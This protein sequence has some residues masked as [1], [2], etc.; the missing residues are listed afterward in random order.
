LRH[1]KQ[2]LGEFLDEDL[3]RAKQLLGRLAQAV[4]RCIARLNSLHEKTQHPLRSRLGAHW[5]FTDFW[6]ARLRSGGF[7]FNQFHSHPWISSRCYVALPPTL[8]RRRTDGMHALGWST[9]GV[10]DI[11]VPRTSLDGQPSEQLHLGHL[12]LFPPLL[13]HGTVA[14]LATRGRRLTLAFDV[15]PQR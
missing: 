8:T 2:T 4:D 1:G 14:F 13:W 6:S 15:V 9:F 3:P 11:G 7:H 12:A 5:R 10:P